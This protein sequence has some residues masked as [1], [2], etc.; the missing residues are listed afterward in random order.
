MLTSDRPR[1]SRMNRVLPN[2]ALVVISFFLA[3]A[4]SEFVLRVRFGAPPAWT[5][6]QESYLP[7][8][9]IG[10]RLKPGQ[11]AFTHDQPVEINSLGLRD[12]DYPRIPA[13]GVRR[14]LALGDSETFGNG[15]T[16]VDSWPKQLEYQL[17]RKGGA[18][19]WEVV[20]AG[21][22]GSATWQHEVLARRISAECVVQGLV[23]GFY[24]NDV[25]PMR[26]D[27]QAPQELTNTWSKRAA[28]LLKR[29]ALLLSIWDALPLIRAWLSGEHDSWE[30]Q[31]LTG[32]P[33]RAI[34][35]GWRQVELS[36][37]SM[38]HFAD[39]RQMSFWLAAIPRRDQVA[40][41]QAGR[42]YE[43]RLAEICA[44]LGIHFFDPLPPLESSYA[45]HGDHLFIPWDGHDTKLANAVI[46]RELARLITEAG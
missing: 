5:F 41:V 36:L 39:D 12:R 21:L 6:P 46:A 38:K 1:S 42:A 20:N 7:D 17:Q 35:A 43:R 23:L 19:A 3:G 16:L 28:Y 33:N 32:S 34:D 11:H 31:I 8:T 44:R 30:E 4:L 40:G 25:V 45:E 14:L 18:V 29:S 9:E 13:P 2:I 37:E 10:F 22:P 26:V 27:R 24:V 15:L